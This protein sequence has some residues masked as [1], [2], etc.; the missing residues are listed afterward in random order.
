MI[1]KLFDSTHYV[2]GV[3][4]LIYALKIVCAHTSLTAEPNSRAKRCGC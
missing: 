2:V 3:S 4:H 1:E